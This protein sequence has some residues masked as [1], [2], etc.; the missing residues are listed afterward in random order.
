MFDMAKIPL[1]L[2]DVAGSEILLIL[3]FILIFFGSK[4]IPGIARTMGR[5]IR[6]IKEASEEVQNEIRK[7]GDGIKQDFQLQKMVDETVEDIEKP[8]RE[9][10]EIIDRSVSPNGVSFEPPPLFN[11]PMSHPSTPNRPLDQLHDEPEVSEREK[12]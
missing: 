3:V 5:T 11:N 10:A 7:S 1:F 12:K 4:S 6:Q 9:Q 2:S 8:F